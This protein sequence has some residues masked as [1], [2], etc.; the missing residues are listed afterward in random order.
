ML[1]GDAMFPGFRC[2]RCHRM[3]SDLVRLGQGCGGDLS[4]REQVAHEPLI[5][6]LGADDARTAQAMEAV[7]QACADAPP[8]QAGPARHHRRQYNDLRLL[9]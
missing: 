9:A 4:F 1:P 6:R 8:I 3:L 2:S 7:A 5:L